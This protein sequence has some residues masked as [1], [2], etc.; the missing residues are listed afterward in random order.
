MQIG[1]AILFCFFGLSEED[2]ADDEEPN[3]CE[4]LLCPEVLDVAGIFVSVVFEWL[5]SPKVLIASVVDP[6]VSN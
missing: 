2:F 4:E 5:L 3:C 6:V 1:Y